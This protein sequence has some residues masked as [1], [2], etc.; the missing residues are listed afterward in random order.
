MRKR[1]TARFVN[2]VIAALITVF[3]LAHGTM[4]SLSAVTGI[5]NHFPWLVWAAVALVGVH[6]IASA[7][8]SHQQL[9]DAERPPSPR[10]KRHLALKWATGSVLAVAACAH[11]LLPRNGVSAALVIVAV[12]VAL[13][14]HLCVG[15]K[16]LLKDLGIGT[17]YKTVFRV[18]VC[19]FAT[20]FVIAMIG[21]IA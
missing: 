2:G 9:T 21:V 13:A 7:V 3:F 12:S 14:V 8:T 16:S 17:R 19:L 10:K 20:L 18:V 4:G 6:V 11:I 5:A 1:V 15:S